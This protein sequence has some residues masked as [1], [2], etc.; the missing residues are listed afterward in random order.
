M[1]TFQRFCRLTSSKS[2]QTK[3]STQTGTGQSDRLRW[4]EDLGG[5]QV[6]PEERGIHGP[7]KSERISGRKRFD[8]AR[9]GPEGD[10]EVTSRPWGILHQD[11]GEAI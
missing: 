4:Q 11:S 1:S 2:K 10:Y 9:D 7:S 6:L 8:T 5:A 3:G